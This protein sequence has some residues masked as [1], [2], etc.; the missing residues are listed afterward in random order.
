VFIPHRL[1]LV[2]KKVA[3]GR[4]IVSYG[5]FEILN[6]YRKN[7]HCDLRKTSVLH[8][9]VRNMNVTRYVLKGI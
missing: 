1:V 2:G 5:V 9:F 6:D 3:H 8:T 4:K 7:P